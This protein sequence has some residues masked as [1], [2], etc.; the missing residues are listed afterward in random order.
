MK[1]IYS[2]QTVNPVSDINGLYLAETIEGAHQMIE[3]YVPFNAQLGITNTFLCGGKVVSR[4]ASLKAF[5]DHKILYVFDKDG[6]I[7][8]KAQANLTS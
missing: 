8:A 4:K 7:V 3:H 6:E 2:V 1:T 5:I